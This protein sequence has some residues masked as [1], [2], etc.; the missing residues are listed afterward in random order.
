MTTGDESRE[1]AAWGAEQQRWYASLVAQCHGVDST[2]D[3][4]TMLATVSA[5]PTSEC[6]HIVGDAALQG[7]VAD[8]DGTLWSGDE[9]GRWFA[10]VNRKKLWLQRELVRIAKNGRLPR[11]DERTSH[12]CGKRG[13]IRAQHLRIQTRSEDANDRW[14][15]RAHGA[16]KIRPIERAAESPLAT[17]NAYK[18]RSVRATSP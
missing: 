11:K 12:L 7:R 16:G 3:V 1:P 14:Y 10:T 17:C 6:L 18:R 5:M 9:T 4:P 13:C 15:H 8:C 2:A